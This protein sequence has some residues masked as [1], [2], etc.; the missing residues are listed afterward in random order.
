MPIFAYE[1][2][3]I[4]FTA[5]ITQKLNYKLDQAEPYTDYRCLSDNVVSY[6]WEPVSNS[7]DVD[8]CADFL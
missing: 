7:L 1:I 4:I 6:N 5:Y 3:N 8:S 2:N